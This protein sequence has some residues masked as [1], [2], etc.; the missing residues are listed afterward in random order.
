LPNDELAIATGAAPESHP[1]GGVDA[2][3]Q[4]DGV[5]LLHTMISSWRYPES[6]HRSVMIGVNPPGHFVWDPETTD[7][8]IQH[9]ADLCS[10]D[11]GCHDRTDDLA[12]T[13]RRT[14][15]NTPDRWLFLPIKEGNVRLASFFGLMESTAGPEPLRAPVTQDSWLSASDGDSSG[16]W[17]ASFLADFTFPESF[18][19][20]ETA[21]TARSDAQVADDYFAAGGDPGSMSAR[22]A[23]ARHVHASRAHLRMI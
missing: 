19:W 23:S 4:D 3:G 14:A 15:S 13:M 7:E 12:A 10:K 1:I 21:A 5:F 20:G 2:L 22:S 16:F 17:F 11:A 8:Q 9:Y 18:V 6:I